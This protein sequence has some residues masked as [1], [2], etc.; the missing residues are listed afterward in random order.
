MQYELILRSII[1]LAMTA[2]NAHGLADNASSPEEHGGAQVARKRAMLETMSHVLSDRSALLAHA[3][4]KAKSSSPKRRVNKLVS[5]HR[6]SLCP[7]S[8]QSRMRARTELSG[9]L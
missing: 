2:L 3:Q 1:A 4:R 6:D 5:R 9:M 8:H 7:S